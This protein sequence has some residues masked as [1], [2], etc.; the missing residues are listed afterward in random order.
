MQSSSENNEK[1]RD[2]K[3]IKEVSWSDFSE[4]QKHVDDAM[5]FNHVD[6]QA[7]KQR[8]CIACSK[9]RSLSSSEKVSEMSEENCRLNACN[10]SKLRDTDTWCTHHTEHKQSK[11]DY[12]K[13]D[14][15]QCKTL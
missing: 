9:L 10:A 4:N 2:E 12:Q 8:C 14:E 11:N 3:D 7:W 5:K 13:I 15:R 6:L 1:K